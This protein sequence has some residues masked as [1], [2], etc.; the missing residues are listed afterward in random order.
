MVVV[1][2]YLT[3]V[4]MLNGN[5]YYGL[6]KVQSHY[7]HFNPTTSMTLLN[8]RIQIKLCMIRP[9]QQLKHNILYNTLPNLKI[10]QFWIPFMG[11]HTTAIVALNLKRKFIGIE[12]DETYYLNAVQRIESTIKT[13]STVS[14]N[15]MIN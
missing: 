8:H 9:S 2:Q 7:H 1:L 13:L 15:W 6:L 12:L 10:E 4:F 14:G 11:Y 3:D 5:H